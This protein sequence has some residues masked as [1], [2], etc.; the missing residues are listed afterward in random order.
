M[1]GPPEKDWRSVMDELFDRA[2]PDSSTGKDVETPVEPEPELQFAFSRQGI[3]KLFAALAKARKGFKPVLKTSK[4]PFFKSKY[5]DLAEVLTATTDALSDQEIAVLQL[6]GYKNGEAEIV[7]V[8]GHSSGEWISSKL[9]IPVSKPDAQGIGSAITYSRRYAYSG[10]VNVASEEDDDGN[11]AVSDH[12]FEK[13]FDQRTEGQR[14][15]S[16]YQVR[17]Y[18]A[19]LSNK[20]ACRTEAQIKAYFKKLGI[21]QV[22]NMMRSDFN[23]FIKWLLNPDKKADLTKE[24][25]DSVHDV[26]NKKLNFPHMFAFAREKGVPEEDIKQYAYE[27]Y[28]IDHMNKLTPLQFKELMDWI[29]TMA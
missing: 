15:L 20:S 28:K 25:K 21:E 8:V 5:A 13:D 7:T 16:E 10:T 9:P 14:V 22:G 3:G 27:T 19:A 26:E 12:Q 11:A 18:E 17:A 6:P 4:N 1:D 29:G 2:R 24:L 23:D